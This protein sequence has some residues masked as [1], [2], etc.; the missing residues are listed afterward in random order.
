M[1]P[2]YDGPFKVISRAPKYFKV[3]LGTRTD[4][5]SI[6]RLKCAH[7]DT[8]PALPANTQAENPTTNTTF[9]KEE[10]K[11]GQTLHWKGATVV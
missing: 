11:V 10:P 8:D 9:T 6:D 2:P 4:T 1:Q 7:L 3:D 5:V